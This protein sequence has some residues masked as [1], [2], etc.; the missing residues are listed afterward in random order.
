MSAEQDFAGIAPFEVRMPAA[1]T[2]PFVFNSPHS[3][4]Y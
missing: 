2:A 3:G 1:Q 4:R